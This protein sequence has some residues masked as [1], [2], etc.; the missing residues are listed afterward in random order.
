MMG[1]VEGE[2]KDSKRMVRWEEKVQWEGEKKI[3][4]E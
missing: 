2:E 4:V 3:V 1:Q